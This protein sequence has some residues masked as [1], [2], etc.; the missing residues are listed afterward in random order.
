MAISA[1]LHSPIRARGS[2]AFTLMMC[3]W[4][5]K[6]TGRERSVKMRWEQSGALWVKI[7][8]QLSICVK[9]YRARKPGIYTLHR[10]FRAPIFFSLSFIVSVNSFYPVRV[11]KL[12]QSLFAATVLLL[13]WMA[14]R[15]RCAHFS[16]CNFHWRQVKLNF[17]S[18]CCL[19]N[20]LYSLY[21]Y[22]YICYVS[23]YKKVQGAFDEEN[24]HFAY[25]YARWWFRSGKLTIFRFV[26]QRN[27]FF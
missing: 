12:G 16:I 7:I 2:V 24:T 6:G 9:H 17:F 5:I 22:S 21:S 15:G 8:Y 19:L 23:S 3:Q 27:C 1:L 18:N 25:V 13:F 4:R 10:T 20:I 11:Q 26:H 14:G